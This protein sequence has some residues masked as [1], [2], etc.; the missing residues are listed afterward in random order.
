[1]KVEKS[2]NNVPLD[3]KAIASPCG[4]IGILINIK[5]IHTSMTRLSYITIQKI[6]LL[7]KMEFPGKE[8]KVEGLSEAQIV[9]MYNG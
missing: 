7:I 5:P 8:T 6:F 9:R 2:W 4:S 3:H 1:M